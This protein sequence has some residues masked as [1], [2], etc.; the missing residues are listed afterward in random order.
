MKK[1][2]SQR[3]RKSF[4]TSANCRRLNA[5]RALVQRALAELRYLGLVKPTRKKTDH[6]AKMMWKG[7]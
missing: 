3:P 7:L 1:K 5:Y 4:V 2:K 6:I